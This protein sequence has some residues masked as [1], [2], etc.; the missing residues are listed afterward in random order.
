MRKSI[1]LFL[2][3]ALLLPGAPASSQ[4]VGSVPLLEL[5]EL[6]FLGRDIIALS[7]EGSTVVVRLNLGERVLWSESRGRVGLVITNERLL[8]VA[9]GSAAWQQARF[10]LDETRPT[11]ALLGDRVA[12]AMTSRRAL[13]FVGTTGNFVEYRIGPNEAL[14]HV[15]VGENVAVIV[16]DRKAVGLSPATGGFTETSLQLRERIESVDTRSTLATVRTS[17]R[18]LFFRAPT[19]A[20]SERRRELNES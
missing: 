13:G 10:L 12:V 5:L 14:R 3:L 1:P 6:S 18:L 15:R 7:G 19:G 8:A 9:T 4:Q 16:T 20:W 2:L 11:T 17:R